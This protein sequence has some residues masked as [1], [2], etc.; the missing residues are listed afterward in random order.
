MPENSRSIQFAGVSI[1]VEDM[2]IVAAREQPSEYELKDGSIVKVRSVLTAL[3]RVVG[4]T[5]ADGTP[6]YLVNVTPVV[7]TLPTRKAPQ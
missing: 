1:E 2:D 7:T 6:I 4:Q 5:N 3:M